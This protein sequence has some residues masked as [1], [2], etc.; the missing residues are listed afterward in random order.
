MN[1]GNSMIGQS[2]VFEGIACPDQFDNSGGEATG[3]MAI[4]QMGH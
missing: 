1:Y 2:F 4:H 3:K